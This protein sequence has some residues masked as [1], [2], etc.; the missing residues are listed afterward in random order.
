[1]LSRAT[2]D[3]GKLALDGYVFL[4]VRG[5]L[6]QD[7]GSFVDISAAKAR[8]SG[9]EE[10]VF[11]RAWRRKPWG[12]EIKVGCDWAVQSRQSGPAR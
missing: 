5:A 10:T 2:L 7:T 1:M 4:V 6:S 9:A 11:P 3:P 12:R 8:Q